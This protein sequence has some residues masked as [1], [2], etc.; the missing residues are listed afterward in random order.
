VPVPEK[1]LNVGD[2]ADYFWPRAMAGQDRADM[3]FHTVRWAYLLAQVD[4]LVNQRSPDG[5][6]RILDIGVSLQTRLLRHNYPGCVDTLDI[7]DS[8]PNP[9]DGQQS[10]IFDLNDLYY[11][12]RRPALG[13]FDVIVMCEVIEHL[14]TPSITVLGSIAQWL[15]PGGY[16]FIQTPNAVALHKR[17]KALAGRHPYMDLSD[18][19]RDAPPHFREYTM[20]EL[21]SAGRSAGLDVVHHEAH[22]YFTGRKTGTGLYNALCERLPP[23]FRA[24]LSI[25]YQR[26]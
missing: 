26:V 23:S 21:I 20:G 4:Q 3:A 1:I 5:K 14:Y 15:A 2:I 16:L 11:E 25:T 12:E 7:V 18:G 24:G 19:T 9:G 17:V 13:P 10:Q 22:N 6:V 8:D